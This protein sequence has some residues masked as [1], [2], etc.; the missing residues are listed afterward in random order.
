MIEGRMEEKWPRGRKGIG[1]LDDRK[2]RSYKNVRRRTQDREMNNNNNNNN[3]TNNK[4]F[5]AHFNA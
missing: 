3:N 5:N 4:E 1:M 2:E